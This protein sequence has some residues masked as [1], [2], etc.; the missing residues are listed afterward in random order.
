MW[1]SASNTLHY[2][3]RS[4]QFQFEG[5]NG[6]ALEVVLIHGEAEKVTVLYGLDGS[7]PEGTQVELI[8]R[9][10][11]DFS[12]EVIIYRWM[13]TGTESP[14]RFETPWPLAA[15]ASLDTR[16]KVNRQ[17]IL[18]CYGM[19]EDDLLFYGLTYGMFGPAET[20]PQSGLR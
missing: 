18:R 7:I 17:L 6:S 3:Q 1:V 5:P 11:S 9:L 12:D 13:F 20:L 16:P 10:E 4:E 8:S 19:V 2:F 15:L 14:C